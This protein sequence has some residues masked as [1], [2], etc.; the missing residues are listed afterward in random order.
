M[1]RTYGLNSA[2]IK[3]R[4]IAVMLLPIF[5]LFSCKSRTKPA[6]NNENIPVQEDEQ[7]KQETGW[8]DIMPA[9]VSFDSYDGNRILESGQGFFVTEDI[10]AT[11]YSL[12]SQADN[13]V[14]TPLDSDKKIRCNKYVAVDRINDI[15]LLKT[16]SLK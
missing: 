2:M 12:V 16:D 7:Q 8:E 5:L 3:I 14:M 15:I 4:Y 6:K 9:V 13:I 1:F 11:R 10:I